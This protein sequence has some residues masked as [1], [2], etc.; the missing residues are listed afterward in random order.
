MKM[1]YGYI[2]KITNIQNNKIYIG[3]TTKTIEKRLQDHWKEARYEAKGK[4]PINYFHSA[5]LKYGENSFITEEIDSASDADEL[6]QKEIYWIN[7][8]Q[9][10]NRAI[11]YNLMEGG[12]SGLKSEETKAKISQKKKENW[13][14][15]EL[16]ERMKAGLAKGTQ[17]WIEKCKN[18]RIECCCENCGKIFYLPPGEANK[19]KYCSQQCANQVNIKKATKQASII[20][21]EQRQQRD[22]KYKAVIQKWCIDHREL[23]RTCPANKIST[24]LTEMQTIAKNQFGFSDWRCISI[25][26]CG[27][28]SKKEMLKY[29][30][31]MIL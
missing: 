31:Q 26:I 11:G 27:N 2:Y 29:L 19:R 21:S 17:V 10:T 15:E 24:T 5:L 6:N 18:N 13:E 7:Y 22:Q 28:P 3:Q 30:K 16:A 8:Y 9:S 23:I 20:N 25:A 4:R 14:N 1:P 12:K